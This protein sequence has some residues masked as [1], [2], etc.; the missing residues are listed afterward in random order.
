MAEDT[1][2]S[3]GVQLVYDWRS[4]F[5]LCPQCEANCTC[6]PDYQDRYCPRHGTEPPE[7]KWKE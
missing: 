7:D 1:C 5:S 2:L 6:G 3:H 4:G